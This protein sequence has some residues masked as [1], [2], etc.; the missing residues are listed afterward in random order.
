MI[1]VSVDV[2]LN[3]RVGMWRENYEPRCA[4]GRDGG[5]FWGSGRISVAIG[6]AK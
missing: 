4:L 6:Q 1:G 5:G 2:R 3:T